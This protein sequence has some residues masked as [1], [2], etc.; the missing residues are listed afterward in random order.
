[1][2]KK[3]KFQTLEEIKEVYPIGSVFEEKEYMQ[4]ERFYYYNAE[5]LK[6]YSSIY[7][8]ENVIVNPEKNTVSIIHKIYTY[9][10]GYIFDGEYWYPAGYE[11]DGWYELAHDDDDDE[12]EEDSS[13]D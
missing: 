6:Y 11:W 9:V 5:D 3:D 1:M 13:P 2:K 10:K 7:G 12:E 8:K 4:K